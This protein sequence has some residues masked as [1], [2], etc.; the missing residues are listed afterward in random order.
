MFEQTFLAPGTS[1]RDRTIVLALVL[2]SA[3]VAGLVLLPLLG[4]EPLDAVRHLVILPPGAL[5]PE[6]PP[7]TREPTPAGTARPRIGRL[8]ELVH[9]VF[10]V[11]HLGPLTLA[12]A[13]VIQNAGYSAAGD[14][15][16][17]F[18]VF[19]AA[20][21][22]PAK[23]PVRAAE[24]PPQRPVLLTSKVS[25]SQLIYGPKPVYPKLALVARVEGTVRL[26]AVISRT[27]QIENLHV[28]SG[29]ALLTGAAIETVREWRYRPL[30]L[31]GDPA[32][33]ITEIDVTF[34]LR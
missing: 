15:H 3:A 24:K 32:E 13:P 34:T 28:L 25:L 4:I 26:Q 27:G 1:R 23:P 7:P 8:T 19:G 14:A 29:P 6:P 18:A 22:V 11:P 33:V 2:Q 31:N 20:A 12:D 9:P 16:D 30:L 21:L 5:T 17:A 10:R